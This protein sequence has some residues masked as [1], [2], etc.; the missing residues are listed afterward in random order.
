MHPITEALTVAGLLNIAA[1][2]IV[3]CYS[4]CQLVFRHHGLLNLRRWTHALLIGGAVGMIHAGLSGFDPWPVV[5][6]NCATALYFLIRAYRLSRYRRYRIRR[7][8][9]LLFKEHQP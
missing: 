9:T 5:L 3:F 1:G 4:V 8:Q 7:A 6:A 2:C